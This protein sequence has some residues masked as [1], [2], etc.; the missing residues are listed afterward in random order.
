VRWSNQLTSGIHEHPGQA[1]GNG[2]GIIDPDAN[3]A[4]VFA[5]RPKWD[6]DTG[7]L[8]GFAY[9]DT[10][11]F[12]TMHIVTPSGKVTSRHLW[13]APYNSVAHDIWLTPDYIVMPF[14]PFIAATER[15]E[16]GLGI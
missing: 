4:A 11:P 13:D 1:N 6:S 7:E 14:Q 16:K 10:E 15:I 8:F 9:S 5:A 2:A 12:V 3:P